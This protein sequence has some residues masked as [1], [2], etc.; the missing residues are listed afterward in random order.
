MSKTY[1]IAEAGLNHN[2]S[3]DLAKRLIDLAALSGADA[4]KFQKRTIDK[5]AV[6]E[7][8]DAVDDR[9]PD[10]G[11]TYREIREYLEFNFDQYKFLKEY[12]EERGLDFICTA[13]DETAVDF[14]EKLELKTYKLA[15]HSLTN[16]DLLKYIST[17]KKKIILSTGMATMDEI[18]TAVNIFQNNNTNLSLLHCVSSYP[19]PIEECNLNMIYELKK[20]FDV[21][22]GYS[23]HEIGFLPTIIAVAMGAEIIER[24]FTLDNNL[25]GFDHKMSLNPQDLISMISEIRNVEKCMGSSSKNVSD[26]EWLTRKKYHVSIASARKILSGEKIKKDMIIYKNPG[27]GIPPKD[28]SKIIGRVAKNDINEDTL[29]SY[30]MLDE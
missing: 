28:E 6:K 7:T 17:T 14:L 3:I 24:H 16:I 15:S 19:T 23:G 1:I 12:S 20:V 25:I 10:F 9:F 18:K 26:K 13:F 22:I 4:V 5:L 29:I 27:T 21:P 2:G 8:L 30:E 11:K